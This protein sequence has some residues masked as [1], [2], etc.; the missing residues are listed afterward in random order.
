MAEE[1]TYLLFMLGKEEYGVNLSSVGKIYEPMPITP[2]PNS[3][4][5]VR[6]LI[7]INEQCIVAI[8]IHERIG[9]EQQKNEREH[10]IIVR[11][12]EHTLALSVGMITGMEV[13]RRKQIEN[14]PLIKMS[15]HK[16]LIEGVATLKKD[17]MVI[18]IHIPELLKREL[19]LMKT[20]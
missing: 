3:P 17:R 5:Y 2:I 14:V 6:G 12:E 4:S 20:V 11:D 8:D 18:L 15:G 9:G 19:D 10:I 1:Q 13:I 7:Q 16:S